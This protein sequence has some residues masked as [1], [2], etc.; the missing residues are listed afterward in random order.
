[1]ILFCSELSDAYRS[2]EFSLETG[3]LL[4]K[5]KRLIE[6]KKAIKSIDSENKKEFDPVSSRSFLMLN[7]GKRSIAPKE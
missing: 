2:K 6:F 3:L 7:P 4:S 5:L 1:L